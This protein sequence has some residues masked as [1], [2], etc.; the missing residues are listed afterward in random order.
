MEKVALQSLQDSFALIL[1]KLEELE[2]SKRRFESLVNTIEGNSPNIETVIVMESEIKQEPNDL[3]L[4]QEPQQQQ[5]VIIETLSVLPDNQLTITELKTINCECQINKDMST[6]EVN[7][8][9]TPVVYEEYEEISFDSEFTSE[10]VTENI[11]IISENSSLD[12][13]ISNSII[14][15]INYNYYIKH[16]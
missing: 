16:L 10:N 4:R 9:N 15:I 2:K 6:F 1:A 7:N 5:D 13:K 14:P 11:N 12:E 8:F 3:T